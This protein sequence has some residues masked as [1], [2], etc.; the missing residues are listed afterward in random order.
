MNLWD[1][2]ERYILYIEAHLHKSDKTIDNYSRY[3]N[4]FLDCIWDKEVEAINLDDIFK[5]S[6]AL[7]KRITRK[8]EKLSIKT[9]NYHLVA[10]RSLLKYLLKNDIKTLS[11][12]K[13]ELSKIGNRQ[14]DFLLPD[15][16]QR[17]FDSVDLAW[18]NG[19]RDIAI[20]KCLY[21]TGLR[22]SELCSLNRDMINLETREFAIR[23]KGNKLRLVF[24]TEEACQHLKR[25]LSSRT[26]NYPPLF[27]S[28]SNRGIN[29]PILDKNARRLTR[30]WVER[31]VE[32]YRFA[33]GILKNV[34]PHT[35]RHS[36]ATSL[37]N[38]WADIRDVQEMLGH[39]SIT[40]TQVY[41]HV[42][43]RRLKDIHRKCL[44]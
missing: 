9:Q 12:D 17:L 18:R 23:W 32:K 42:T 20:L 2:I 5:F 28:A 31:I 30:D 22:V 41:T 19:F 14:V 15:E 43:N 8:G 34:T 13:V 27:I 29:A 36:F 11:S 10:V 44:E 26:D 38:W 35:L 16:V 6:L 40:T 25:Y 39:N 21:S 3:L 7:N 37:L 4:S 1:A 33:S 24:L